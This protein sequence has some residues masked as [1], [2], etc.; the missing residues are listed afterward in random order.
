MEPRAT[1]LGL[2]QAT[3]DEL[4]RSALTRANR[5][6]GHI[7]QQLAAKN[8]RLAAK[9]KFFDAA[10]LFQS[11]LHVDAPPA[12]V[13]R[14]VAHT[15]AGVLGTTAVAA[16]SL[17]DGQAQAVLVNAAGDVL[18]RADLPL[19]TTEGKVAV[20]DVTHDLEPLM[21]VVGP[22]LADAGRFWTPLLADTGSCVGGVCWGAAAG[23]PARLEPQQAEL[24]ALAHAWALALCTAQVRDAHRQLAD[25][26]ADANRQLIAA[27]DEIA[28]ARAMRAVAEMAAGAGHEMNTPLAVMTGRAELLAAQLTDPAHRRSA[29]TIVEQGHR[30]SAII[31]DLMDFARP[32]PPTPLPCRVAELVQ[33]ALSRA[34]ALD[35][36]TDRT[37]VTTVPTTTALPRVTVDAAQAAAALA[38][39]V[40][41]AVQA[42]DGRPVPRVTVTAAHVGSSP[43]VAVTVTDNG[44]GMDEATARRAFD[45]FFS[46]RPAGRRRGLGLAKALRWAEAV[47]GSIRLDSQVGRGT[48]AVLL[49]PVADAP[50]TSA[51]ADPPRR[52]AGS[53]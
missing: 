29:A 35:P 28:H 11:Q 43:H 36:A 38:E 23:E 2:G 20:L 49:W 18:D 48:T 32:T 40:A 8:R 30:L 15:A 5:E 51:A 26:L 44:C 31:T 42:T 14:A 3:G 12:D 41:N 45:P 25:Q 13:L 16:F 47:G 53:A 39:L 7:G 21:A 34:K 22:R 24:V 10:G 1:A 37:V 50:P 33:T 52:R 4:Y 27:Q 17:V 46:G 9:S 19:R 6:L